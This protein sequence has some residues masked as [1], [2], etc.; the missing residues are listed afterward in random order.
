MIAWNSDA[1]DVQE[2]IRHLRPSWFDRARMLTDENRAAGTLIR[3]PGIWSEIKQLYVELQESKC[4]YCERKL[5]TAAIEWDVEHF[6]PKGPVDRWRS[7]L[8]TALV[9]DDGGEGYFLLAYVPQNYLASCKVCNSMYK[10]N[11]FP[12]RR[13][14]RFWTDDFSALSEEQPYLLNPLDPDDVDP[15][16]AIGFLGPIPQPKSTG[17]AAS[18]DRALV[19]IQI[20]ALARPDLVLE[21]SRQ[22][23][24]LRIAMKLAEHSGDASDQKY[25][26]WLCHSSSPH[27]SCCR[28]YVALR[29][30]DPDL[31]ERI[32]EDAKSLVA[33]FS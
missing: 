18:R 9:E 25:I 29:A 23:I 33:G 11:Y 20:L 26:A 32:F 10:R 5:G 28:A 6:R 14:H 30:A 15:E 19:T 2:K 24:A 8:G 13:E 16:S 17:D 7:A 12:V 3:K 4:A 22:L 1:Q 27:S 21:R 31:A